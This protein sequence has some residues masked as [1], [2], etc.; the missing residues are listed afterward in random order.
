MIVETGHKYIIKDEKICGGEPV[1]KGT[2]V[3]VRILF[4]IYENS[5]D[6]TSILE[7][8]PHLSS[9]QIHDALSYA[10]DNIE[11]IRELMDKQAA[12]SK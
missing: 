2:R 12:F 9:G 7:A 5:F 4:N 8:Y 1:I 10:Y 6:I 3:L 11:E